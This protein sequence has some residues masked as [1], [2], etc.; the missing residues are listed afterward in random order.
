MFADKKEAAEM[1]RPVFFL[2]FSFSL[3]LAIAGESVLPEQVVAEQKVR[4]LVEKLASENFQEREKAQKELL[5]IGETGLDGLLKY[6]LAGKR[7]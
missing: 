2:L 5:V 4:A 1:K 7:P 6:G 3:Q